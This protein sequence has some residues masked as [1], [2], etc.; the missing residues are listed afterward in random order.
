V[1]YPVYIIGTILWFIYERNNSLF[2]RKRSLLAIFATSIGS[3][4]IYIIGP[5]R[6]I[7]SAAFPCDLLLL[8]LTMCV[9]LVLT[10]L[11]L[12]LYK[13]R[14]NLEW[15]RHLAKTSMAKLN[16]ATGYEEKKP[17]IKQ[18]RKSVYH[19]AKNVRVA[20]SAAGSVED[21]STISGSRMQSLTLGLWFRSS[22]VFMA[23]L[24]L[25]MYILYF[26]ILA[27]PILAYKPYYLHGCTGCLYHADEQ[28][29][30][31]VGALVVAFILIFF[32]WQVWYEKDP[33]EIK[34]EVVMSTP[35]SMSIGSVGALGILIDVLVN[36]GTPGTMVEDRALVQ[37]EWFLLGTCMSIH[38]F[39]CPLQVMKAKR[40]GRIEGLPSTQEFITMLDNPS[41]LKLFEAHC[42]AEFSVENL[43]FYKSVE[44]DFKSKYHVTKIQDRDALASAIYNAYISGGAVMEINIKHH[45]RK[46]LEAFFEQEDKSNI[47]N[48]PIEIFDAAQTEIVD[49]MRKDSLGRWASSKEYMDWA[50]SSVV[51]KNGVLTVVA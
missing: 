10:P 43:K 1:I 3:F 21:Q 44:T 7:N 6:N 12:R 14:T 18:A 23:A 11:A 17:N 24:G 13:F 8:L 34:S 4:S 33:L 45:V 20:T 47:E 16:M 29:A 26:L 50:K 15:N 30:A 35:V 31:F 51:V 25:G 36:Q 2:L 46:P 27:V 19:G 9:P 37:F 32:A 41:F 39:Q 28:G 42:V 22:N 48:V 40:Y 5:V 38:F 49:L